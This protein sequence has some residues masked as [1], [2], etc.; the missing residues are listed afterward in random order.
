MTISETLLEKLACPACKM[1]LQHEEKSNRLI[2]N[3]CHLGYPIVDDIPVLLVNEAEKLK[4][5]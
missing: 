5:G 2:C 3:K 4:Q 1:K